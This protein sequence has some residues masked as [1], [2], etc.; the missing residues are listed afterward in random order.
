[1][2]CLAFLAAL[3]GCG[4]PKAANSAEYAMVLKTL[5]NPFWVD[6]KAGIEAKAAELGVKVDIVAANSEDDLQGQL[7]LFENLLGKNYKG[8][9]FAPLSPVNL[10][11]AASQAYAKGI[12]L[13]NIDEKIDMTQLKAANANVEGFITTDNNAVGASAAEYIIETIG[14]GDVI[15]IEGKAGN[16]SGEARRNG[17]ASVFTNAANAAKIKL[18]ASQPADWDRTKA[19]DVTASLLQRFPNV[20]AIYCA[21]DTMALGAL[22]AVQNAQKEKEI[23]VIGTDGAPEA[24]QSVQDGNMRGTM[25]QDPQKI[26]AESLNM[27]VESVKAAKGPRAVTEEPAIVG[28]GAVL[29]L[30]K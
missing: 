15:I 18:V 11:P 29:I 6:L 27:L 12:Y 23:I 22:Q 13:V 1:M 26:G 28:L 10:I 4:A 2:T 7:Q 16:V 25:A 17:A 5:G 30:K 14:S 20:K 19:L 8:I 21:N 24:R 3:T 9:G